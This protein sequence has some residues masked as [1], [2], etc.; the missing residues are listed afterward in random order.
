MPDDFSEQTPD[1]NVLATET[2]MNTVRTADLLIDRIGSLVRPLGVSPAGGL[3]LGLLRDHGPMSPSELGDRLIVTRSTITGVLHSL[4][5]RGLLRR[6]PHPTDRRSL[7]VEITEE[8]R[9]V[10]ADVRR[11]VHRHEKG[12]MH[13]LADADLKKLIR[14][15]HRVQQSIDRS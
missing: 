5:R 12:W 13:E 6:T 2:V 3:I 7:V 4:E 15:L 9:R 11:I 1:G 14:L 8:G 10:L